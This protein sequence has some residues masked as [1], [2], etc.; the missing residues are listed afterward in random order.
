MKATVNFAQE[1]QDDDI[2]ERGNLVVSDDTVILVTMKQLGHDY[3]AG[4][5]ISSNYWDDAYYS[6]EWT[7]EEFK[8]FKG[9]IVL[10]QE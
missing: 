7:R 4:V 9:N 6:S 10:E 1:K 3:F 2:F 5:V 8:L